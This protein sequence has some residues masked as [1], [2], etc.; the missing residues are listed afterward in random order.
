MVYNF[1]LA[2]YNKSAYIPNEI[3]DNNS[4]CGK[5]NI[6]RHQVKFFTFLILPSLTFVC[7][8]RQLKQL[9]LAVQL[10]SN[11]KLKFCFQ[12]W[13]CSNIY[14][15]RS[16]L[17]IFLHTRQGFYIFHPLIN[18]RK[19]VKYSWHHQ[20]ANKAIIYKSRGEQFH[21]TEYEIWAG[22]GLGG[23]CENF[24][25]GRKVCYS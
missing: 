21:G 15:H 5:N 7:S 1:V 8:M 6:L 3:L 20:P 17:Q 10:H 19:F 25:L 24:G 14:R 22:F 11:Y 13:F 12:H 23:S 18:L 4:L 16:L 2:S 9:G